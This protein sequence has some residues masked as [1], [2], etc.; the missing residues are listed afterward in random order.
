VP[1]ED[2]V[3]QHPRKFGLI[4]GVGS[5]VLMLIM[6]MIAGGFGWID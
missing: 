5:V 6:F 2:Y 1:V 3:R 4:V